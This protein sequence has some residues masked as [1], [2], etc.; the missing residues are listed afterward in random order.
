MRLDEDE[1]Q[2]YCSF[3]LLVPHQA[4]PG[5][6]RWAGGTDSVRAGSRPGPEACG[7]VIAKNGGSRGPSRVGA[8]EPAA[9]P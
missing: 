3:L 7:H 8:S 4:C 9:F 5:W 6:G 1:K 2:A